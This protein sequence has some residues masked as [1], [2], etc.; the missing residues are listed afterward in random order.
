MLRPWTENPR[1]QQDATSGHP[2]G[3]ANHPGTASA[4]F[5]AGLAGAQAATESLNHTSA[6]NEDVIAADAEQ[7]TNAEADADADAIRLLDD[8]CASDRGR[9]LFAGS[10]PGIAETVPGLTV[11]VLGPPTVEQDPRVARQRDEDKGEFWRLRLGA[12]LDAAAGNPKLSGGEV[13]LGP[14]PVRWLRVIG[15]LFSTDDLDQAE[16]YLEVEANAT[17]GSFRPVAI[18]DA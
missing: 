8:L 11:T 6:L 15:Q 18:D 17:G 1:L 2:T 12:S 13:D 10:D 5:A 9:Y 16:P 7:I 14:G 4:A 3:D